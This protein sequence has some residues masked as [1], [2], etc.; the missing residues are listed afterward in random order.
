MGRTH[1]ELVIE[2]LVS[3]ARSM[4]I[5]VE[6]G[7]LDC[8]VIAGRAGRQRIGSQVLCSVAF[9]W[10]ASPRLKVR[11]MLSSQSM[12]RYPVIG[13]NSLSGQAQSFEELLSV[14]DAPGDRLIQCNSLNAIVELTVA[15]VGIGS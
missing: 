9:S 8:A 14:M 1:P 12:P 7:T 11:G 10:M 3:Q 5:E 2:P 4:E 15:G 13:P 6:R